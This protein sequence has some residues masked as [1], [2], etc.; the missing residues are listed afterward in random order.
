MSA[1][2]LPDVF[3]NYALGAF[4]EVV[5]PGSLSWWPQTTG[6]LCL[7]L[8]CAVFGGLAAWKK[9]RHWH[10]N[11]YRREAALE[12]RKLAS[13]PAEESVLPQ[14]NRLLKRV[15]LAAYLR[16]DVAMLSGRPWAE[17][18]NQQCEAATFNDAQL[19]LLASGSYR[20]ITIDE[21]SARGLLDAAVLW[22]A[23]H[24]GALD[25]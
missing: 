7:G 4:V 25:V 23:S 12:I 2:P 16:E 6:W 1:P 17:F 18:L 22:I 13:N 9:L 24:R 15:A 11:R 21:V 20:T 3:G 8:I 14:L 5:P 19:E 10:A